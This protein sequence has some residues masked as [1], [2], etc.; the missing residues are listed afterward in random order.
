MTG[1]WRYLLLQTNFVYYFHVISVTGFELCVCVC[2]V[3]TAVL[4]CPLLD[5]VTN[6]SIVPLTGLIS[7]HTQP[8]SFCTPYLTVIGFM[9]MITWY[10]RCES[11]GEVQF[12][13]KLLR[14]NVYIFLLLL[15]FCYCN[16]IWIQAICKVIVARS[17]I[18]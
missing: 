16:R 1:L 6:T 5:C 2:A 15:H 7:V 11:G 3:I 9:N 17:D 13:C 12:T 8:H 10:N 18:A 14:I 4:V